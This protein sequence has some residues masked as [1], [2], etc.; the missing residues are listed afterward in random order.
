MKANG[1]PR[2]KLD[3]AEVEKLAS[4]GATQREI[5]AW[6]KISKP[7]VERR[8]RSPKLREMFERGNA[9]FDLSIR[10]KQAELAMAGNVTM[11]VWLGKQRLG[12][13]DRFDTEHSGPEGKPIPVIIMPEL[14]GPTDEQIMAIPEGRPKPW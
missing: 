4:I 3:P 6:F 5:A 14:Q 12:Q 1:R 8:L 13:R 7:T 9:A 2:A 11:L 10:R